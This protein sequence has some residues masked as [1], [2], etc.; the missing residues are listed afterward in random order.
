M[1]N[2]KDDKIDLKQL[3][4]ESETQLLA[5]K[6]GQLDYEISC[7]PKDD[8]LQEIIKNYNE[9]NKLK[10]EHS[11]VEAEK[12]EILL[13]VNKAGFLELNLEDIKF[14]SPKNSIVISSELQKILGYSKSELKDDLKEFIKLIHADFQELL[15]NKIN[16]HLSDKSGKTPF[17]IAHPVKF[18]DGTYRWI[19]SYGKAKRR[20]DGTPYHMIVVMRD[21]HNDE[22]N[23]KQLKDYMTR[24]ELIMD[25]LE[26][27]PWDMEIR[28]GDPNNLDNPW[29]W[30]D[31]FRRTLGY[32]NEQDFPNVMSSW[33][34]RLHPEDSDKAFAAFAAHLN[35]R[36]GRTPFSEE[37]RLKLKSGEYRWFLAN[38]V[39]TRNSEGV[40][41]RVAGTIRDIT[42]LKQKEI[43]V[44]ETTNRMEQLSESI[45][46]MV[47]GITEIAAQAQQLASTQEMTTASANEAKMLADETKKISNFIKWIADQT[48]LLGLNAAIEAARAGELGR[49]FSV[50][51]EEVRKLADN[52]SVATGNIE[53]SLNKMQ[54]AIDSIIEQMGF[55]ND[56]AQT[57][58]ALSE[59]VNASVDSINKMSVD[60]VEFAKRS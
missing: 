43:T 18:K 28:D 42:H 58:A 32:T 30:S 54:E 53:T 38:G 20:E 33:S 22:I 19:Q 44:Q 48:N 5:A 51:A 24:Y 50:V 2:K 21:I 11:N 4:N 40:P 10:E 31:Q 16:S 25:V 36:T 6:K 60:L 49:G 46:E 12:I 55:V 45:S 13:E 34:S 39:S 14:D 27:A 9:I 56:L 3:L 57:Q 26:E 1:F 23:K 29:W 52:S 59:E 47:S 35:D 37:Y 41:I 17:D 15:S 8:I 7:I